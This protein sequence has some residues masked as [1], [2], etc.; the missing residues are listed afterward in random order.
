MA[1]GKAPTSP[2]RYK[3]RI[4]LAQL[5]FRSQRLQWLR[6]TGLGHRRM[7]GSEDRLLSRPY[8]VR[9]NG[10]YFQSDLCPWRQGWKAPPGARAEVGYGPG[11]VLSR[12]P[13]RQRSG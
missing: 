7:A 10:L 2:E 5:L 1:I 8:W 4:Q 6:E 3:V 11:R 9:G 12:T 13:D